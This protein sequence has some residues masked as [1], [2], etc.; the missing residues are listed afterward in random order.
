MTVRLLRRGLPRADAAAYL[1]ISPSK[2]D[3]LRESRRVP[4]P[5]VIDHKKVWDVRELDEV[6][7]NL[8]IDGQAPTENSWADR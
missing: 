5:R 1:G 2:F 6:F 3:Q 4:P 8:P 7:E